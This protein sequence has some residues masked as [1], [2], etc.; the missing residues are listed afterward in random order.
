MENFSRRI[1]APSPDGSFR[2]SKWFYERARGQYLDAKSLLKGA[3][4][5]KFEEEYPK[6]QCFTKTDLA[7][8]ECVWD[9]IPHI[10]SKGAQHN[11]AEFA[12]RVGM[13]WTKDKDQFNELYFRSAIARAIIFRETEKLISRQPWYDGGYRAQI[14]AYTVAKLADLVKAQNRSV[15]LEAIWKR[16]QPSDALVSALECVADAV[17]HVVTR[18]EAGTAN[19]TEWA[20]KQACW[21]RVKVLDVKLPDS[22]RAELLDASEVRE[23][24]KD[25]KKVQQIDDGIGS[26]TR[27]LALGASFW[28]AA[29]AFA[30]ANRLLSPKQR[31]VLET[32]AKM[33]ARLPSESQSA[34]AMEALVELQQ[35]GFTHPALTQAA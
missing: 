14:V 16:Q 26:Q 29:S 35:S 8:F 30:N 6:A 9:D 4:K 10:V 2:E 13:R 22:F 11:F 28:S 21:A 25:A 23:V 3:A 31:G 7:K 15:D 1:Y 33:P 19:I 18:P 27:V 20:K 5:K 24:K 12:K 32:A 34:I 17:R